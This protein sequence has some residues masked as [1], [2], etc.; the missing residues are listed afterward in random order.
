MRHNLALKVVILGGLTFVFGIALLVI[1]GIVSERQRYRERVIG[2]VA[3]S[4]ARSQ[5]ITGP[6]LVVS[7]RE[8]S[9][10]LDA[11]G[12]RSEHMA[13]SEVVLLPD[14]LTVQSRVEV[15]PRFRG[16]HR[17]HVYRSTQRL[18]GVFTIPPRLGLSVGGAMIEADPG[19]VVVG[20]SDVRGLRRPPR[21]RWDDGPLGMVPG[22][23]QS[24]LQQG[25][26]AVT[27]PL[28]SSAPRRAA[29]EID[30]ELIGTDRLAVVPL[31]GITIA[32]MESNWPHPSFGGGFLPDQRE[33]DA[34]GF[35]AAWQ[36]SRFATG[37]DDMIQHR[38][39]DGRQGFEGSDF[40]VRFVQP[41]DVYQQSERAVKYGLLFVLLT[42][43][44]FFLFEVLRRLEVHPIQYGLAGAAVALFFLLLVSL[45]EHIP[46]GI[47][48]LAA[49][50]ACVGLLGFY[51]SHVLRSVARGLGFG[52]LLGVLYALLYLLLQSE[53]YALLLGTLLLFGVVATVMV[54]T[55]RVDWYRFGETRGEPE[56]AE[57]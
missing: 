35:R 42:F 33:L 16:I 5:T 32:Q 27:G 10:T 51:V 21:I 30:F 17:A 13:R 8:R 57:R 31:G 6:V 19:R 43:L 55:R 36:L 26:S 46:F 1:S 54:M 18:S 53:D 15:E 28:M 44:A 14:S 49:S 39:R 38:R 45:S 47:A 52:A 41:V 9:V 7:Y 37:A 34:R 48:Y 29:F 50:L 20:V 4:T 22:T 23:G 3:G 56:A 24:W 12:R 40:A 2:E 11:D 25:F